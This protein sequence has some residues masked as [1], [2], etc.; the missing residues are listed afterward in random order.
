VIKAATSISFSL[1]AVEIRTP[2]V[3]PVRLW[4]FDLYNWAD[5]V[6]SVYPHC[7]TCFPVA[8]RLIDIIHFL[9]RDCNI[10]PDDSP[11]LKLPAEAWDEP[12]L[13][14]ECPKCHKPLKF[15]PFVVDN[16]DRY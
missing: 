2:V 10:T 13:L 7:A 6:S 16:R 15:N 14:S 1:R 5:S 8:D 12:G 4:H 9:N 11:C 3:A